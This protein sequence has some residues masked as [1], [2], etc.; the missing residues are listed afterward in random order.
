MKNCFFVIAVAICA[1]LGAISQPVEPYEGLKVGKVSV[2]FE[3]VMPSETKDSKTIL[4]QIKTKEGDIFNQETFDSDLKKLSDTYEWVEPTIQVENHQIFIELTIKEYPKVSKFVVDSVSYKQKKLLSEAELKTGM[5]YNRETFY[6]PMNKIRD[7][8]IK[9]GFFKVEVS[10]D[11]DKS[12]SSNDVVVHIH[13]KEGDRGRI[14][15]IVLEN[16]TKKEESE[17]LKLI[18]TKKFNILTSWLTGSGTIKTESFDQDV[19]VIVNMLQN[20]GFVDANV[21]MSV[22]KLDD[23]KLSLTI[24]LNRGERYTIN[25]IEFDGFS[26][27]NYEEL[28]NSI[29]LKNGDIYSIDKVREAQ[30]KI[31]EL[32][33]RDGYINTNVDSTLSIIPEEHAYDIKFTIEESSQYRVGLVLIAGNYHTDKNVIYNNIDIEPG[34]V[35]DSRKLKSTQDKLQGTG[36]FNNV[37]VYPMKCD[38]EPT[39][40]ESMEYCDVMI[41]V[42]EAQTGSMNMVIGASSTDNIFGG[43]E[44]AENNFDIGGFK[45]LWSKGPS[46][47]RGG[48]QFF[49]LKGSI[50]MKESSVG[51]S[52]LEP[53]FADSLWRIGV[54]TEY[55][56]STAI[57][58][59][60]DTHTLG[61]ALSAKYPISPYFSYGVQTRVRNNII[62][63]KNK[64]YTLAE[65]ESK[66]SGIV[67]G[68]AFLTGYDSTD[69]ALKAK[70]GIRSNFE[71]EFAGLFRK[72]HNLRDFPFLKLSYINSFYYPVWKN[73]VVKLRADFRFIQPM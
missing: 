17:V 5:R 14:N 60:Y 1:K 73:G 28:K 59:H 50:G 46:A 48:G 34:E 13:V 57:S 45:N 10:Y 39:A 38:Q 18:R 72:V 55:A 43:F 63:I 12:P 70:R 64:V 58:P 44:I 41:E 32:Y 20:D 11:V 33:T 25:N 69:N 36:Y 19:Q 66:N 62:K 29:G 22:D 30:E 27:K 54:D 15:K 16:F 8:Y 24:K 31:K 3:N 56:R 68:V 23:N 71:L 37:N 35:F 42:K 53:Y 6:K 67:T 7:F 65:R 26:L 40:S 9:K 49:E 51:V 2:H 61:G 47:F 21:T 52:W 4:Y